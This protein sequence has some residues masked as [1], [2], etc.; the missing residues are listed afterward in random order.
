MWVLNAPGPVLC[1]GCRAS[2]NMVNSVHQ[3]AEWQ[4]GRATA[5]KQVNLNKQ[6]NN[7][8]PPPQ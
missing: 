5:D 2:H 3:P 8:P 1:P 4:V 7:R 6:T